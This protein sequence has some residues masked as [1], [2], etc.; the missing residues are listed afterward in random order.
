V[1]EAL[2]EGNHALAVRLAQIPEQIRGF[3]HVKLAAVEA[4]KKLEAEL[5]AQLKA[6][7]PDAMAA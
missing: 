7:A 3:G 5:L 1:L 2:N 6:P 4:A